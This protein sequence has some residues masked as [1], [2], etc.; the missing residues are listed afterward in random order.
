[1]PITRD[2]VIYGYRFILGRDPESE[3]II[4]SQMNSM[5]F[6]EFRN[7]LFRSDEFESQRHQLINLEEIAPLPLDLPPLRI[8]T[9]VSRLQLEACLSKVKRTW[10]HLGLTSPH[11]SVLTHRNFLPENFEDN[12]EKFWLSSNLDIGNIRAVLNRQDFDI[13]PDMT[14]VEYGCGV[15]RTTMQLSRMFKAVHAYDISPNHL[16]IAQQRSEELGIAN[17]TFHECH[18]AL[19]SSLWSCDFFYS[20]IV[21]QHNPPPVMKELVR[22]ALTAINPGGV[23]VFQIPTYKKNYSFHAASWIEADLTL[24]MEMHCLPQR[25]VFLLA[26]EL[27]CQVLEVREDRW[28]GNPRN[29]ISNTFVLWKNASAAG[30]K[31]A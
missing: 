7:A 10:S 1:M 25:E 24:E 23:A 19:P 15:G 4:S 9:N 26:Q 30:T 29:D 14:A 2:D 8:D 6:S 16:A 31:P 11:W 28:T 27:D 20:C 12:A 5:D 21:F 17:I 18:E 22:L 13:G 3:A